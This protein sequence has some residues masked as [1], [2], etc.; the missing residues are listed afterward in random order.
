MGTPLRIA[1]V[2]ASSFALT[3]CEVVGDIFKAGVWTGVVLVVAVLGL[4]GWLVAKMFK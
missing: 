1:L 4:I 3:G 2:V